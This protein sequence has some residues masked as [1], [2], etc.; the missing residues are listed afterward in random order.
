[1]IPALLC[2]HLPTTL[3]PHLIIP[4]NLNISALIPITP[5]TPQYTPLTPRICPT[6]SQ[7]SQC[8]CH[9]GFNP[10]AFPHLSLSPSS[11][12][13]LPLPARPDP[14]L[15]LPGQV[16]SLLTTLPGPRVP[17]T[18]P[19]AWSTNG[20]HWAHSVGPRVPTTP[21]STGGKPQPD[22]AWAQCWS[23]LSYR[24][25]ALGAVGLCPPTSSL[26]ALPQT[27]FHEHGAPIC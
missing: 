15:P 25:G 20:H 23:R 5:V 8:F 9:P 17:R 27:Q 22:S 11:P 12:L 10:S 1:M 2:T 16:C 4:L 7:H 6:D 3:T 18:S 14:P 26:S 24:R 13:L 21:S 19:H